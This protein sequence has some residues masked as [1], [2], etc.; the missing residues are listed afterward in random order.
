MS[1]EYRYTTRGGLKEAAL[2][3]QQWTQIGVSGGR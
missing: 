1:H 3:L 2:P